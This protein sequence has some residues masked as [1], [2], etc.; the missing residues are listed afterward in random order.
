MNQIERNLTDMSAGFLQGC[1]FLIYDRSS[2]FTEQFRK[3]LQNSG[4]EISETRNCASKSSP[5]FPDVVSRA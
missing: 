3:I 2:L 5:S 4:K 1:R